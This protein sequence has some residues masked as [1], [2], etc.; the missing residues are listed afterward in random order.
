MSNSKEQLPIENL[1]SGTHERSHIIKTCIYF[2]LYMMLFINTKVESIED[3]EMKE[4]SGFVSTPY[5]HKHTEYTRISY[6]NIESAQA[7]AQLRGLFMHKYFN[8]PI[9]Y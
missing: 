4:F 1:L 6:S 3:Q 8:H 9:E 5:K 2:L 7:N